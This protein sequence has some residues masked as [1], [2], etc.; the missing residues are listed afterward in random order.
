MFDTLSEK[1][2]SVIGQFT[3]RGRL[4]EV[5]VDQGLREIRVALLEADVNFRVAGDLVN[6]IR[7]RALS[8]KVLQ[9]L[10]P[11]EQLANIIYEEL[12]AILSSDNHGLLSSPQP[13]SVA[14][15][16]GLQGS[17]KTT[18]SGKLAMKLKRDGHKVLLV[19]ADLRRPAA[20]KQLEILGKGIEVPV[21][22]E[23]SSV[24][25][26][27]VVSNSL[28]HA[29][30][31]AANWVIIDTAG[32]LHLDGQLMEELQRLKDIAIPT[33]S[34]LVVD[35]MTGQ[36][37]VRVATEFHERIGLTGLVLS[38][39][40][41]DARGGAALSIS[42]ITGVPVKFVGTGERQEDLEVFHPDRLASRIVG[43]G[44]LATLAEK[45]RE[46]ITYERA[47]EVEKKMRNATFDLDDFLEQLQQFKRMGPISGIMEMIPGFSRISKSIPSKSM[48]DRGLDKIEAIV[49][50]MTPSERRNP[51]ILNGS[52]KRRI[53]LGSGT[54]PQDVNQL[55]NQFKQSK[56]LMKQISSGRNVSNVKELFS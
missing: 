12:V 53:A 19:A 2:T 31:I 23:A 6:L 56:K 18:T 39:V 20:I 16:V 25:I 30:R 42:K 4:S 46:E 3:R 34:L 37:A 10:T 41:G 38:K 21:H 47:K 50:S 40:D 51:E 49:F 33:E 43:M 27:D 36:D 17:G 1:L 24:K 7:D 11:G 14:F 29:K 45:A 8:S 55:L 5:D 54:K 35:A 44:D 28:E 32:R 22:A 9:S 52:R 13:P 48:D 15:I 26:E